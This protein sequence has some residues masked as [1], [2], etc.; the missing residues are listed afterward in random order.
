MMRIAVGEE[1]EDVGADH[2][3]HLDRELQ[4]H[5]QHDEERQGVMSQVFVS[6]ARD[7]QPGIAAGHHLAEPAA[8]QEQQ[9]HDR[10]AEGEI[11]PEPE[12]PEP[13]A[14]PAGAQLEQVAGDQHRDEDPVDHALDDL[15]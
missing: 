9:E 4:T 3:A 15:A 6:E 1:P 5:R 8:E 13:C 10:A 7:E 2:A 12:P 14:P 11:G